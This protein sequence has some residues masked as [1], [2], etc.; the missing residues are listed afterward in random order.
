VNEGGRPGNR[1]VLV[2]TRWPIPQLA[3]WASQFRFE[4]GDIDVRIEAA[5]GL[6]RK[7]RVTC[8]RRERTW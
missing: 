6:R 2:E 5:L 8:K 4:D 3:V 7:Y 1:D